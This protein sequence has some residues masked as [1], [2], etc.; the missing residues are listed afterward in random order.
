M[1]RYIIT[2]TVMDFTLITHPY[3]KPLLAFLC[4][5]LSPVFPLSVLYNLVFSSTKPLIGK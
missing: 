2:H 4:L 5:L 1:L 3:F